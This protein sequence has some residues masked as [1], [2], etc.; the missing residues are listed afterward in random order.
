MCL[1]LDQ[2]ELYVSP[3]ARDGASVGPDAGACTGG[4]VSWTGLLGIPFKYNNNTTVNYI[5]IYTHTHI[6]FSCCQTARADPNVLHVSDTWMF[7]QLKA[8]TL[9]GCTCHLVLGRV[10]C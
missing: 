3:S 1:Y 5:D 4:L 9:P 2:N 6:L 8:N 10:S 7:W